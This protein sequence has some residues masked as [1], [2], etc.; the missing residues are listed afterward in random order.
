[1]K[2]YIIKPSFKPTDEPI[3]IGYVVVGEVVRCRDCKHADWLAVVGI[4]VLHC[5][6]HGWTQT[7]DPDGF[8]AWG[9]WRDV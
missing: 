9:K 2:E 4:G 6:Y 8:C 5:C 7:G 1:M 3:A